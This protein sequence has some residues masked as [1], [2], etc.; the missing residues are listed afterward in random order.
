M[1]A[2]FQMA[3]TGVRAAETL[4]A[5]ADVIASRSTT[6]G[7]AMRSP[8]DADHAELGRMM[9]EKL[10]AFARSGAAIA[11]AWWAMGSAWMREAHGLTTQAMRGRVPT[12]GEMAA[13]SDRSA[14]YSLGAIE[15]GA[16][17]GGKALAPIHR[18]ATSNARRLR[19]KPAR[20]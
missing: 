11:D 10:D 14:A 3:Q 13:L 20:G 18:T 12:I 8:L 5:S 1:M 16:R 4:A 7:A 15:A 17:L 2:G 19:R 6:I 9:P